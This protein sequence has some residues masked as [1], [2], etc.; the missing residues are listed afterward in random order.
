MF[1]LLKGLRII[2]LT[3]VVLG[4]YATQILGDL[5]AE[6]IKIEPLEGDVFR[7]ARPGRSAGLGAHYLNLNR[8]K[9]SL[10]IDLR[11]PEGQAVLM[12]LVRTADVLVHNMRPASAAKLGFSYEQA[13]ACNDKLVYCFAPGFGQNGPQAAAPAYDDVI[14]A[15]SGVAA[16]NAN[17]EGV[18]RFLPT[19][20]CDK[21]GGLHLAIAVL[22]GVVQK[23]ATGHGCQIEAPMFESMVSFLMAEQLSGETFV[24]ALGGT[25]YERLLSPNRRPFR[26]GNGYLS[27][28]PYTTAHWTRFLALAGHTEL[29]DA[30]WVKNAV[31]RS[32]RINEL[33]KII[34]DVAP[35]RSTEDW[36]QALRE[37]DIPCARVNGI[38][39][40]LHDEHLTAVDFF[41][42]AEHPT[43]GSMRSVRSPFRVQGD[44]P[45]PDHPAPELG[46]N[47]AAILQ[48][49]GLDA[50]RIAALV[51]SGVIRG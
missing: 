31:S 13:R 41:P 40:L 15:M 24:P 47:S 23:Q 39:D 16:L 37:R 3:T 25:G 9:A 6:V 5:G 20:L 21:I 17:A 33:Y 19:I 30:E 28:L 48:G 29:A 18:P 22:G 1:H 42:R 34:A 46:E 10:A 27:I 38:A 7:A 50:E 51:A 35:S 8:N 32:Q 36:L 4:P 26:T 2:D 45:S 44:E 12:Q 49:A 43:Q 11:K 14:Q